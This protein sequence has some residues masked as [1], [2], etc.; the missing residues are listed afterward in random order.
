MSSR[1]FDGIRVLTI[2][3]VTVPVEIL[4][5]DRTTVTTE[6]GAVDICRS[7]DTLYVSQAAA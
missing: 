6:G 4:P 2:G 7:G 3:A 1:A 5:A